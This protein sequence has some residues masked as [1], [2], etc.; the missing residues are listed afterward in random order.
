[1]HVLLNLNYSEA[2][3]RLNYYT[4]VHVLNTVYMPSGL[5]F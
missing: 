4:R 3:L 5:L 2:Q 1:M